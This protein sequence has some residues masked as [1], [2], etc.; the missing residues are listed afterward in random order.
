MKESD[1][2]KALVTFA[3]ANGVLTYKFTSPAH[4]GVPDRIFIG[5]HGVLFL[6]IKQK[7]KK[8]EPLQKHEM[9]QINGVVKSVHCV[10]Q[11]ADNERIGKDM[12]EKFCM[13]YYP[14]D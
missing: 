11:W 1:I 10:A 4:R 12:I 6:E 2:E 3:E 9:E 7:G 13:I 14:P 5:P 8:P